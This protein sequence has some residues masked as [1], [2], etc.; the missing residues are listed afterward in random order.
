MSVIS[1]NGWCLWLKEA[2]GIFEPIEASPESLLT[3]RDGPFSKIWLKSVALMKCLGIS[4]IQIQGYVGQS[5]D[6]QH[7]MV[8]GTYSYKLSEVECND[9]IF[10]VKK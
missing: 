10:Y 2:D 9:F 7:Y 5:L 1:S 4:E 3:D 8:H 6:D